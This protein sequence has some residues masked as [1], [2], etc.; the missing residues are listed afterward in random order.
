MITPNP[1]PDSGRPAG[2]EESKTAGSASNTTARPP[3]QDTPETTQDELAGSDGAGI[4]GG[5]GDAE[6]TNGLEGGEELPDAGQ[7][8]NKAAGGAA[9]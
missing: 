6:Q 1:A 5:Y 8:P 3:A 9:S 2:I 4:R 7:D